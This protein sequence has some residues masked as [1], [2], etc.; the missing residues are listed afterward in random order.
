MKLD[1][2]NIILGFTTIIIV[3]LL[4]YGIYYLITHIPQFDLMWIFFGVV[5]TLSFIV[6]IMLCNFIGQ[7]VG[8]KLEQIGKGM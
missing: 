3:G 5:V 2:E 1:I 8:N 7:R 4:S 6:F